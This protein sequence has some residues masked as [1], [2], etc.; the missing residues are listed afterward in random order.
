MKFEMTDKGASEQLINVTVDTNINDAIK[1]MPIETYEHMKRYCAYKKKELLAQSEYAI[2][3]VPADIGLRDDVKSDNFEEKYKTSTINAGGVYD[4]ARLAKV[5]DYMNKMRIGDIFPNP[6]LMIQS[7]ESFSFM[8]VQVDGARRLMARA[9]MQSATT[10][11]TIVVRRRDIVLLLEPELIQKIKGLHQTKKWF[12]AYQEIIELRLSGK[13]SYGG[14]FPNILDFSLFKGKTV[15][16]FGCSNGM[17]LFEAYYRGAAK[18]IGFEFVPENVEIINLMATRFGIP[19]EAHRIDFNDPDWLSQVKSILP[20][21]DYS[22]F[23]ST[24][25]TL[26][27]KD[28]DGLVRGMWEG[29]KIGMIFEGHQQAVDTDKFYRNVF[30][31]KAAL[32]DYDIKR[33]PQGVIERPYDAGYRPKYLLT[34]RNKQNIAFCGG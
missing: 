29:S 14:R 11:V 12:N 34:K 27:L 6:I 33:L 23:L 30:S 16:E 3:T 2:M 20:E 31:T 9:L 24:Y 1:A 22:V 15:A 26:E 4:P 18:V 21:W 7:K 17:A 8:L 19:V 28:R 10:E 5:Y 32:T 25:R 13:R